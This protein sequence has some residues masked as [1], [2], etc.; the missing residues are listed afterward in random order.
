MKH[1]AL[2]N[3][4]IAAAALSAQLAFASESPKVLVDHSTSLTYVSG[5]SRSTTWTGVRVRSLG[6]GQCQKVS[7][8]LEGMRHFDGIDFPTIEE[9]EE[10]APCKTLVTS[11]PLQAVKK[12]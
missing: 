3:L 6:D 12:Q 10:V 7:R 2:I 1:F 5:V 8:R 9:T 11:E 4:A